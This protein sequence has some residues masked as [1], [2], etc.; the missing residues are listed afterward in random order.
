VPANRS[1]LSGS[2]KK[3]VTRIR[4]ILRERLNFIRL[5][6]QMVRS[7][8]SASPSPDAEGLLSPKNSSQFSRADSVLHSATED[9]YLCTRDGVPVHVWMFFF[10]RISATDLKLHCDVEYH[11]QFI[12]D[13]DLSSDFKKIA[14]RQIEQVGYSQRVAEHE[15]E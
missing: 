8:Y 4:K 9:S 5:L 14:G 13:L 3:P 10:R 1:K 7:E 2:G 15:G 11:R 6:Y 12:L